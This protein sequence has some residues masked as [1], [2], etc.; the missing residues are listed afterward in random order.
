MIECA[1]VSM[2]RL[3]RFTRSVGLS[4]LL[5][6]PASLRTEG[7]SQK[8]RRLDPGNVLLA[9]DQITIT[10]RKSTPQSCLNV[11]RANALHLLDSSPIPRFIVCPCNAPDASVRRDRECPTVSP[12]SARLERRCERTASPRLLI[13][14]RGDATLTAGCSPTGVR[15]SRRPYFGGGASANWFLR[16]IRTFL[17]R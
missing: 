7:F 11:I 12:R 9:R 6:H 2:S 5:N 1:P 8:I 3:L 17:R 15:H 14:R 13:P 16:A 4:S 10:Y